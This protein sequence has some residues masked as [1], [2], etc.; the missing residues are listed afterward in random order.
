MNKLLL[1]LFLVLVSVEFS[2]AG[3][4]WRT[5]SEFIEE[6]QLKCIEYGLY[7]P[8]LKDLN[9]ALYVNGDLAEIAEATQSGVTL[10][11][12]N[13]FHD[14]AINKQLCFRAPKNVYQKD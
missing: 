9:I 10:V 12:A 7:K 5:E 3:L 2:E 6:G 13:T 11:K 8:T 14:A 1:F 4:L